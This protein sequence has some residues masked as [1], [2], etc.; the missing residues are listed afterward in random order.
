MTFGAGRGMPTE[1]RKRKGSTAESTAVTAIG[2][3]ERQKRKGFVAQSMAVSMEA[4]A[5]EASA[6]GSDDEFELGNDPV[7]KFRP[8]FRG[9]NPATMPRCV[10]QGL[11]CNP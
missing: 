9:P 4:T 6:R 5:K 7:L 11:M 2:A 10:A 3:T 1:R 8:G